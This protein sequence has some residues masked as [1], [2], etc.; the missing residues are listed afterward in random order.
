MDQRCCIY[1]EYY[2]AIK[3]NELLICTTALMNLKGIRLSER[4]QTQN[5]VSLL[6]DDILEKATGKLMGGGQGL[7]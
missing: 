1:R 3:R 7:G 5:A 2:A 4:S 6:L